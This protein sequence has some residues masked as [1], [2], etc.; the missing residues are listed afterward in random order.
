MLKNAEVTGTGVQTASASSYFL[1]L[2]MAT[3]ASRII[4]NIFLYRQD[5]TTQ[6][7]PP[8]TWNRLLTLRF[9]HLGNYMLEDTQGMAQFGCDEKPFTYTVSQIERRLAFADVIAGLSFH[10]Q[11]IQNHDSIHRIRAGPQRPH[12][13]S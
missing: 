10:N 3:G 5:V 2:N 7:A 4:D 6:N 1:Q 13:S 12:P 8:A 9:P 11:T